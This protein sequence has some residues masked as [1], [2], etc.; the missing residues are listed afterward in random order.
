MSKEVGA[1][2]RETRQNAGLSQAALAAKT[3]GVS[4]SVL[5]KAERGEK[6]LSPE[7]LQALA[8]ALEVAPEALTGEAAPCECKA[9]PEAAETPE[10][11]CECKAAPEAAEAPA[12][13]TEEE[14][15]VVQLFQSADAATQNAAISALK[16]GKV[17]GPDLTLT[18][19]GMLSG[20]QQS[21]GGDVSQKLMAAVLKLLGIQ[22][23]DGALKLVGIL[24]KLAGS[25]G[26]E[27]AQ[28]NPLEAVMNMV[29]GIMGKK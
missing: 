1:R 27:S 5:S 15:E 29:G 24:T 2:I 19:A 20:G 18:L 17:S 25:Q 16:E 13:M 9:A 8:A 10:T 7:Q 23:G 21:E 22:G 26:G 28:T 4:A 6:E 3:E 11:P 12:E 14:K